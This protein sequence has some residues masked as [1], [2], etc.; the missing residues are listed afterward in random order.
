LKEIID[1]WNDK[2]RH[3]FIYLQMPEYLDIN[4]LSNEVLHKAKLDLSGYNLPFIPLLNKVKH[5]EN[6]K[7]KLFTEAL[8]E[9]RGEDY[10]SIL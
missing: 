5:V 2:E 8:D 6:K 1:W 10:E 9:I 4:V 7:F 3:G